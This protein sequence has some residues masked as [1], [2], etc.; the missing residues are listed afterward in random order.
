MFGEQTTQPATSL[1]HSRRLIIVHPAAIL[2]SCLLRFWLPEATFGSTQRHQLAGLLQQAEGVNLS[3]CR[4]SVAGDHC[5]GGKEA[6]LA[7][8]E[9]WQSHQKHPARNFLPFEGD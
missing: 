2:W 5:S 4:R 1:L 7:S 9:V 8:A 6:A 3:E